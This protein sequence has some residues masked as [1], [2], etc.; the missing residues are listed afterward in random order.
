MNTSVSQ[1]GSGGRAAANLLSPLNVWGLSLG[2]A[3]GWGA[4]MVPA[5]I[6][7]PTAGP[8]G[9]MLAMALSTGLLLVIAYNF[10]QLAEKY[11]DD[12]GIVAYTRNI[13][14]SD[15]AFLAAWILLIAYMSILWA[16]AT[17]NV[18]LA[19]YLLGDIFEW[20]YLYTIADFD[21][22]FGFIYLIFNR[23]KLRNNGN[24]NAFG[25]SISPCSRHS[26][27]T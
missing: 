21:I 25:N 16:N 17:A 9:T 5:N 27:W 10:C 15:H 3:V 20:G 24:F 7:I 23:N 2:C 12:G 6:F 26:L 11:H 14:G 19:R 1:S 18:L 4:F 13:L 22:Y 8:L